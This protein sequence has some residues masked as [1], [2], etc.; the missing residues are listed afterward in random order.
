MDASREL[1]HDRR[2]RTAVWSLRVGY[3]GLFVAIVGLIVMLAGGTRST[4]ESSRDV[5]KLRMIPGGFAF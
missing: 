4:L 1:Q 2:W 5:S 3:V